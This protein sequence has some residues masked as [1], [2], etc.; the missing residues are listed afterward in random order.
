MTNTY[1]HQLSNLTTKINEG[2]ARTNPTQNQDTTFAIP[3]LINNILKK[4]YP[5]DKEKK[6]SKDKQ[7]A[8]Q[9]MDEKL[10]LTQLLVAAIVEFA[11]PHFVRTS[12]S[13]SKK[14]KMES[15]SKMKSKTEGS[16]SNSSFH[17]I[18]FSMRATTWATTCLSR[19]L[20]TTISTDES[21]HIPEL[22]A[23]LGATGEVDAVQLEEMMQQSLLCGMMGA[24][25]D[26]GDI[27]DFRMKSNG[28]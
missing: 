21:I 3:N 14:S 16:N 15:K 9:S 12:K 19:L 23:L 13:Q 8:V 10:F 5:T 28:K 2:F 6:L 20:K 22:D 27:F 24:R 11:E 17:S 1:Y 4:Y 25:S 18:E 7:K 26:K